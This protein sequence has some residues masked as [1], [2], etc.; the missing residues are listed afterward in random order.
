MPVQKFGGRLVDTLLPYGEQ[1]HMPPIAQICG[2]DRSFLED[3]H[4][5]AAQ[6]E[7][8]RGGKTYGAGADDSDGQGLAH[9][10]SISKFLEPSNY[11]VQK[12]YAASGRQDFSFSSMQH[13]SVRK[14]TRAC[15]TG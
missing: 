12:N 13:S 11:T 3:P 7:M 6:D 5:L 15:M 10:T 2:N 14:P 8:S 4:R 1:A 9:G